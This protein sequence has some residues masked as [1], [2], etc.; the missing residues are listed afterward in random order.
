MARRVFYSFHYKL[1]SHRVQ[2]VKQMGKVEGQP[3]LSSN[4]WEEVKRGGDIAIRKWIND[5]MDGKSCLV[6]LIGSRTAGR[7]WVNYEIEK[8]WNGDRGVVGVYIHR[9]KSLDGKQSAKGCNP[10]DGFTVGTARRKMSS[11]VK[12]YDP[13]FFMTS[14][15]AYEYIKDNLAGWVEEA[16]QIRQN[17]R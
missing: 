1:D 8:A 14:K 15:G 6:V 7:K 17:F 16:I 9:L 5:Q 13:G 11:I 3:L 4:E 12:D 2:Q 10:F